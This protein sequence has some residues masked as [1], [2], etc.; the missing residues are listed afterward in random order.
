MGPAPPAALSP[1]PPPDAAPAW[2]ALSLTPLP[3]R[4][5]SCARRGTYDS[6]KSFITST[7]AVTYTTATFAPYDQYEV[8]MP[9]EV[10]GDCLQKLNDAVYGP[11]K[12]WEGFRTPG[13]IRFVAGEDFYLSYTNGGARMFINIEDYVTRSSGKPN[14]QFSAVID[15]MLKQCQGRFH[16]GKAGWAVHQK[17]FDGAASYPK[18]WCD[19]G[20]AV[21]QLD[22]AG[23]FR[24]E[25]DVWRWNAT[26]AGVEVPLATCC[27]AQG[28]NKECQC[29]SAAPAACQ[30]APAAPAVAS[31]AAGR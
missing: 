31:A 5:C 20:C 22:P 29:A 18:T 30:A 26:R 1:A 10:A 8:S 21:A 3:R 7:E 11:E 6:R 17:C 24:G 13:L 14:E 23:K 15:L 9:M 19:F 4:L 27:T 2:G 16:W 28:F 12:L 25:S